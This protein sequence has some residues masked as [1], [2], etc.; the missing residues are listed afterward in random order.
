MEKGRRN[1][2]NKILYRI[3][4]DSKGW[5]SSNEK[6]GGI[7]C[8]CQ[9]CWL[10]LLAGFSQE[11]IGLVNANYSPLV[12]VFLE[13]ISCDDSGIIRCEG[14]CG[15]RLKVVFQDPAEVIV[16]DLAVEEMDAVE[17]IEEP[18]AAIMGTII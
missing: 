4:G 15:K 3:E 13:Q 16:D 1:M 2:D 12:D 8:F 17:T 18:I 6:G 10:E 9:K 11:V 14:R 7:G 5:M